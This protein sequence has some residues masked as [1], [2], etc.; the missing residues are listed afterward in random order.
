MKKIFKS[1][2]ALIIAVV[3]FVTPYSVMAANVPSS[4]TVTTSPATLGY[5]GEDVNFGTKTLADGSIAYCLD[6]T[7]NT[8]VVTTVGLIG[9]GFSLPSV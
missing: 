9:E 1:F 8:P 7:M 5:I 4:I 6:Y 3:S 2:L